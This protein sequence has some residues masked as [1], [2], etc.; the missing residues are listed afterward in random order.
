M[1]QK[2]ECRKSKTN[3]LLNCWCCVNDL[4]TERHA[5]LPARSLGSRGFGIPFSGEELVQKVKIL[6][7]KVIPNL[8][9]DLTSSLL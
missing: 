6:A 1:L 8:F 4:L 9:R 5:E 2:S 3:N 7:D